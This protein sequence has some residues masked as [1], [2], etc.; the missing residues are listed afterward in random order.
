L[1]YDLCGIPNAP[2]TTYDRYTWVHRRW[3]EEMHTEARFVVLLERSEWEVRG[4][5]RGGAEREAADERVIRKSRKR[6]ILPACKI[7]EEMD[8]RLGRGLVADTNFPDGANKFGETHNGALR[9]AYTHVI[10]T[11]AFYAV[12]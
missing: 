3:K 5:M 10:R 6:T 12:K 1:K 8:S 9:T 7:R 2:K 4:I 11:S